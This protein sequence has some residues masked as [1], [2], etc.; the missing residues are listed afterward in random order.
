VDP[1]DR[2]PLLLLDVDGPLNPY[3]EKGHKR[4]HL[5]LPYKTLRLRPSGWERAEQPLRVW[6]SERH[7]P[8]LCRFAVEHDVRLVWATTWMHDANTMIGPQIGLPTLPVI[9]F[10]KHPGTV[11]G[12]KYPAVL[13]FADGRPLAWF[14]DDFR[15][16]AYQ[17]AKEAFLR[18]RGEAPTLLHY[19]D[20]RKGIVAED[21]EAVGAWLDTLVHEE[22]PNQ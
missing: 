3:A 12:W 22:R 2:R 19:V 6:V 9:D 17:Q 10:G 18:R 1:F 21:L 5:P 8:M 4:D 14:D 20:P 13:D 16:T 7:G 15:A 11:E